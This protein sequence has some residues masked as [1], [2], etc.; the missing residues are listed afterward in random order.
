MLRLHSKSLSFQWSQLFLVSHDPT[1]LK[2]TTI[3]HSVMRNK[4]F[5]KQ[6]TQYM[7]SS[8]EFTIFSLFHSK[9]NNKRRTERYKSWCVFWCF[10]VD[11]GDSQGPVD[12]LSSLL[13]SV[14]KF[15]KPRLQIFTFFKLSHLSDSERGKEKQKNK[16]S[17]TVNSRIPLQALRRKFFIHF[18][19]MEKLMTE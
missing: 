5:A 18:A 15:V 1:L 10:F 16:N 12:I 2:T 3:N 19:E 6:E 17:I 7:V 9:R 8:F 4:L 13:M 11:T 14:L